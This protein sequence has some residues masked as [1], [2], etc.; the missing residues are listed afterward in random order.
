MEAALRRKV[1]ARAQWNWWFQVAFSLLWCCCAIVL[2]IRWNTLY[3]G[4][5]ALK[6]SVHFLTSWNLKDTSHESFVFTSSTLG[7]RRKPRTK[8]SFSSIFIPWRVS[9]TLGIRRKPRTKASFSSIFIS[10]TL[11]IR[12][13]P[14]TKASFSHLQLLEFEGNLGRKLRFHIF[15]S[16]NLKEASHE[17]SV[18]ACVCRSHWHGC[19][20]VPRSAAAS[21]ILLRFKSESPTSH[22]N[23]CMK[24]ANGALAAIFF[25]LTLMIFL[26]KSLLKRAKNRCFSALASRSGF[27]AAN[28]CNLCEIVRVVVRTS[29]ACV[30]QLSVCRSHWIGCVKA[31]RSCSCK[32]N[33]IAFCIWES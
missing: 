27:G 2:C 15:N 7:I 24:V 5:G 16:W 19:V 25:I 18:S 11:G 1:G 29:I 17:H 22:C 33:T 20:K 9:S 21:A 32:R 26:W 31:P 4:T 8:A 3:S 23:G 14:R 28:R 6:R 10:S 13:I 30:L 12:R